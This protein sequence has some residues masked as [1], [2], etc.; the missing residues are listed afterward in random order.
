MDRDGGSSGNTA[1]AT[2]ST[3]NGKDATVNWS[4]FSCSQN[5]PAILNDPKRGKQVRKGCT[6]HKQKT[7]RFQVNDDMFDV[8]FL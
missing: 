4:V 1:S 8:D 3:S 7:K 5:L 6:Y 2:N